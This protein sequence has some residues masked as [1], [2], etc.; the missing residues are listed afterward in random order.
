MISPEQKQ[1]RLNGTNGFTWA[2]FRIERFFEQFN[3]DKHAEV[4]RLFKFDHSFLQHVRRAA[5]PTRRD[6]LSAV[7][8]LPTLE[9]LQTVHTECTRPR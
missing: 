7:A 9:R 5:M 1:L 2:Q 8:A 3:S 6:Q 4:T